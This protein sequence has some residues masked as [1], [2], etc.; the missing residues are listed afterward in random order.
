MLRRETQR[1]PLFCSFCPLHIARAESNACT[2]NRGRKKRGQ[3]RRVRE[4]GVNGKGGKR[5]CTA[6]DVVCFWTE[7]KGRR[8]GV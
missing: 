8:V 7:K 6:E 4:N 5:E 3:R 2:L 1:Q